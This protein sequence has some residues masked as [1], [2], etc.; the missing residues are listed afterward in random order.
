MASPLYIEHRTDFG[1]HQVPF[2]SGALYVVRDRDD[3][4][5]RILNVVVALL[6]IIITMPIQL[7]I[8]IVIKLTSRGP[9]LY[10]QTRVGVDRRTVSEAAGDPRRMTDLGGMPFTI[11]KFRTMRADSGTAQVWARP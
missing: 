3:R 6:G 5:R 9:V 11:Y 2:S 7:I 10:K 8:A 4:V 1:T